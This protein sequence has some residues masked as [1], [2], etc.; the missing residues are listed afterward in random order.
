MGAHRQMKTVHNPLLKEDR[1][2]SQGYFPA[3]YYMMVV[4]DME[5]ILPT[6]WHDEWEFFFVVHGQCVF[7]L[8]EERTPL[9]SGDML[10]VP[11]GAVHAAFAVDSGACHYDALVFHSSLLAAPEYD[12]AYQRYVVPMVEGRIRLPVKLSPSEPWHWQIIG[13]IH[14]CVDLL[15][16]MPPAYELQIKAIIYGIFAELYVNCAKLGRIQSHA[17]EMDYRVE[18]MR[19]IYDHI[20]GNSKTKMTVQSLAKVANMSPSYL[21]RFF[22]EMTGQTITEYINHYRVA[23]AALMVES[24]DK[25][26]LDIAMEAGFHNLSYFVNQFKRHMGVTPSEFRKEQRNY[27]HQKKTDA[28]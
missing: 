27:L 21:C 11:A 20:H 19:S 12:V 25:K 22:K 13:Q 1:R 10:L 28:Q 14:R 26:M 3:N 8:N 18:R 17:P 9:A 6:H 5:Q 16:R 7:H 23:Q 4:H 24:T 2:H 15:Q